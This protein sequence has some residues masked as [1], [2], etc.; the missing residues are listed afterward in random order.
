MWKWVKGVYNLHIYKIS[1]LTVVTRGELCTD[2]PR[3]AQAN[4]LIDDLRLLN[5][6]TIIHFYIR[7]PI[8]VHIYAHVVKKTMS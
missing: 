4:C 6:Q 7:C 3:H 1:E 2:F 5:Q 8:S